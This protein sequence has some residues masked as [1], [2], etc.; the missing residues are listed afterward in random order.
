MGLNHESIH[1]RDVA[2]KRPHSSL[3]PSLLSVNRGGIDGDL[4]EGDGLGLSHC[5][6]DKRKLTKN[7]LDGESRPEQTF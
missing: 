2:L 6:K 5:I 7:A 4:I 1:R 3:Q